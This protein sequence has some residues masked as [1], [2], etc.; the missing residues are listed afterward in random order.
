MPYV[1][2][3]N[4]ALEDERIYA[5]LNSV[6][7]RKCRKNIEAIQRRILTDYDESLL[8]LRWH[9]KGQELRFNYLTVEEAFE[10]AVLEYPFR[11]GNG[12]QI[13]TAFQTRTDRS[14]KSWIIFS[15]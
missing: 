9:A 11:F 2:P 15:T 4:L 5:F 8:R 7:S 13:A 1:A 3:V 10:Y 14:M 6:G 12:E